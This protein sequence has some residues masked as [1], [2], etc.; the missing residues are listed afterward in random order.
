MPQRFQ[1]RRRKGWNKPPGSAC[2]AARSRYASPFQPARWGRGAA[3]AHAA[4]VARFRE[5]I[6]SP[7]QA[8]LLAEAR[9]ELRGLDLGCDCRLDL[10]CHAD[11][12]L[13]LVND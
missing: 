5:W 6:T 12:L 2:V 9:R 11:V 4:A 3:A 13:E 7:G 8:G 1:Q 10:P